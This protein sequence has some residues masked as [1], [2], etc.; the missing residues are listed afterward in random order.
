MGC[1]RLGPKVIR[2][3]IPR[4]DFLHARPLARIALRIWKPRAQIGPPLRFVARVE[5]LRIEC[6]KHVAAY[7][8]FIVQHQ[9][10]LWLKLEIRADKMPTQGVRVLA[11]KR[12]TVPAV[13]TRLEADVIG[14][15]LVAGPSGTDDALTH[16]VNVR[17]SCC[18]EKRCNRVTIPP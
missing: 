12:F 10:Q 7:A 4:I 17:S 13:I 9:A 8:L 5:G 18:V 6:P 14:S 2:M 3:V 1:I 16:G 11:I 15:G